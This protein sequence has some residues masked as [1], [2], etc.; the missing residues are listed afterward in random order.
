[1]YYTNL[2]AF[3]IDKN[4]FEKLWHPGRWLCEMAVN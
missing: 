2:M 4:V 3:E 1:M